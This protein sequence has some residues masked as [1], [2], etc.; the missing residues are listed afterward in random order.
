MTGEPRD[1]AAG[2]RVP[3]ADGESF[4]LCLYVTGAT[5]G[6]SRAVACLKGF[7]EEYLQG[8][9]ALEVIDIYQQPD[10]AE[11]DRIFATPTLIKKFP[12][13]PRRLVGDLSDP[14]R[15]LT[16]LGMQRRT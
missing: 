14:Q 2:E 4:A 12:F 11:G 10:L 8:H 13:P 3:P 1:V 16:G 15:L 7:C 6:S 5:S 9:Y